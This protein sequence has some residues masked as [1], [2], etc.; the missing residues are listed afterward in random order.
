MTAAEVEAQRQQPLFIFLPGTQSHLT[1][2]AQAR[3]LWQR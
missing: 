2:A 1:T 3:A